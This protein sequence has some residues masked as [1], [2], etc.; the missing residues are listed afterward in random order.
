MQPGR[1]E[2]C[3]KAEISVGLHVLLHYS[4]QLSFFYIA[5]FLG[6]TSL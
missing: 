2:H 6:D 4:D 5:H 1:V 3:S